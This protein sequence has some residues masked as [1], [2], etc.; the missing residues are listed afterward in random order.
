MMVVPYETRLEQAC[1]EVEAAQSAVER[2][3]AVYSRG[4]SVDFINAANKRLADAHVRYRE[5]SA[6]RIPDNR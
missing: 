2:A 6:G 5:I 4:G 3:R 1:R